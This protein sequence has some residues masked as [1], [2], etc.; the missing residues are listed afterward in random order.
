MF[1]S[2]LFILISE[3]RNTV[4]LNCADFEGHSCNFSSYQVSCL[5][6]FSATSCN[7]LHETVLSLVCFY[8]ACVAR[9]S[10]SVANKRSYQG[11]SDGGYIGIY[12][13]PKSGQVN[14]LWSNNDV[15]TYYVLWN[16]MSIKILYLPKTDFWLR[17]WFI[18]ILW[19]VHCRKNAWLSRV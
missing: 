18:Y 5:R 19:S 14:F 2:H 13:L 9:F 7:W 1:L 12:T 8:C 6:A 10:A 17:L 15:S 4:N 11:R 16:T 3:F